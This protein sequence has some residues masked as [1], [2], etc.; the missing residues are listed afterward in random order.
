MKRRFAVF[1]ICFLVMIVAAFA[2]EDYRSRFAGG[3]SRGI[4]VDLTFGEAQAARRS[5]Y[6]KGVGGGL[7]G[8][9]LGSWSNRVQIDATN[10]V[11]DSDLTDFPVVVYITNSSG[12]GADDLTF[13]FDE[14]TSDG[15]RKKIAASINNTDELYIEIERW[16]DANESA[17]LHIKI[18]TLDADAVTSIYLYFD[19][20]A[21]DNTT[22]VGDT[23]D[24]VVHNV[25]E[26]TYAGVFH[27]NQDPNGDGA[28]AI[29][30]S[31]SNGY[32][33]TPAGNMTTADLVASEHGGWGIAFDGSDDVIDLDTFQSILDGDS[34]TEI[35]FQPDATATVDAGMYV[36]GN[37]GTR[38]YASWIAAGYAI[39]GIHHGNW[40]TAQTGAGTLQKGNWNYYILLIEDGEAT[41]KAWAN[42]GR[43]GN[44]SGLGFNAMSPDSN[45]WTLGSVAYFGI[46]SEMRFSID[47]REDAWLKASFYSLD[48]GLHDFAA[49]ET[50]P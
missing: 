41:I 19:S 28:N 33:G 39:G 4:L 37:A 24:A 15:N 9:W 23:T 35:Q 21:S 45:E 30:D 8:S 14:L 32:T 43:S 26:S 40:H 49:E 38:G 46:I 3:R 7:C 16:D 10:T 18:P 42:A 31:T 48:D 11:V 2:I 5:A 20:S 1:S 17:A 47:D 29:K 44:S 36:S 50:C 27:M 22:Y 6:Y 12:T 13:I 34:N 25:W